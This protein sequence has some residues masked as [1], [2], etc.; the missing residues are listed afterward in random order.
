MKSI[1]NTPVIELKGYNFR[2][3]LKNEM[4]QP[5]GTHKDRETEV[6][7]NDIRAKGFHACGCASTGNAAI[8][9]SAFA[10]ANNIKCTVFVPKST[11]DEILK[12]IQANSAEIIK[13]DADYGRVVDISNEKMKGIYNAN[14]GVCK[15]RPQGDECIGEEIADLNP[16]IVICPVNNGTHL[17]GV[18]HGLKKKKRHP[19]MIAAIAPGSKLAKSISGF[20]QKDKKILDA[21]IHESRGRIIELND[22]EIKTAARELYKKGIYCEPS[23]ATTLAALK[24]LILD[25][26][27][28]K[29][30]VAVCVITGDCKRFPKLI[31]EIEKG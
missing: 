13:I 1:K 21:A 11:S 16:T 23:S 5:T 14:P 7:I 19:R 24:K 3:Y 4:V 20:H 28:N 31:E 17:A 9:L 10:K 27:C 2:L 29:N 12:M 18:W 8:S 25:K 26:D 15:I 22:E 30:D 6:I